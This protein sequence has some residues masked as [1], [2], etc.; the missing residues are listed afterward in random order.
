MSYLR[1][2]AYDWIHL[3]FEDFLEHSGKFED[4]KEYHRKVIK[5]GKAAFFDG[6]A[7]VPFGNSNEP[8][9]A[10]S[11]IQT[12]R[13]RTSGPVSKYK[14]EFLTQAVKTNWDDQA[15]NF[16]RGNN[17]NI[18]AKREVPEWKNNYYGLQKMQIDATQGKPGSKGQKKGQQQKKPKD[19]SQVECYGC[20][21][22][23]HYKN[24][25][26]EEPSEEESDEETEPF[27][28][29]FLC[30]DVVMIGTTSAI[31]LIDS[32][33]TGIFM[34]PGYATTNEDTLCDKKAE[35]FSLPAFDGKPVAYNQRN[36]YTGNQNQLPLQMGRHREKLQFDITDTPGFDVFEGLESIPLPVVHAALGKIDIR[37][38]SATELQEEIKKNP[39]QVQTS[40]YCKKT[41]EDKTE[42]IIPPEYTDFR[43]LFE[44][45]ADEKALLK[46]Q[47][48]DHEIKIQ[49]GKQLK[50]EPLRPMTA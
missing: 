38:M 12:I 26:D 25:V 39:E 24:E 1:G 35:P 4:L 18:K 45:E 21:K 36:D 14:A 15:R 49:E 23:G 22:K 47:P 6:V 44:K 20:G 50:K 19:K 40:V 42:F 48:W 3:H 34:T 32:G 28:A 30:G 31:A 29:D 2:P 43:Q 10:E 37:A 9:E 16:Y 13:Q 27:K 11:E 17:A 41:E 46:H 33:C 5:A 8:M 7:D